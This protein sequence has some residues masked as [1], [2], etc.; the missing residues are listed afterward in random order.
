[1]SLKEILFEFAHLFKNSLSTN[2]GQKTTD[3]GKSDLK[4][5]TLLREIFKLGYVTGK[6][7]GV[8]GLRSPLSTF[9]EDIF[10][11]TN[12]ADNMGDI[13]SKGAAALL[14]HPNE[15][16]DTVNLLQFLQSPVWLISFKQKIDFVQNI[17]IESPRQD[18]FFFENEVLFNYLKRLH[19][20]EMGDNDKKLTIT[21]ASDNVDKRVVYS[22]NFENQNEKYLEYVDALWSQDNGDCVFVP[23]NKFIAEVFDENILQLD[24]KIN[25]KFEF[26]FRKVLQTTFVSSILLSNAL[27][28]A[29]EDD[30]LNKYGKIILKINK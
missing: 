1:M 17:Y 3:F 2:V 19:F 4:N 22:V 8:G 25:A 16:G 21:Q 12:D 29:D 15:A 5:L 13:L 20:T 11:N 30:E 28:N 23:H 18:Y 24:S 9:I 10:L 14:L 6:E 27:N 7:I 26:V